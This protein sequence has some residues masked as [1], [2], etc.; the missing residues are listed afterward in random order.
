[1]NMLFLKAWLATSVVVLSLDFVWL[2]TMRWLYEREIGSLLL[3]SPRMGVALVFYITFSA[4]IAYFCVWPNIGKDALGTVLLSGLILGFAAYGTYDATNLATLKDFT[5]T[6]AL[7]DWAW[8]T[9]LTAISAV[10]AWA[11]LS[12]LEGTLTP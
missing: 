7:V 3:A 8:G 5:L 9:F 2:K 10:I 1:M 6:I 4:A 11:L 12:R